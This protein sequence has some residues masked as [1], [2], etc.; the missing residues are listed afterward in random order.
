MKRASTKTAETETLRWLGEDA[1]EYL[2][3]KE[4]GPTEGIQELVL[5][6]TGP[7]GNTTLSP[8]LE[9]LKNKAVETDDAVDW[10]RFYR[11]ANFPYA[12]ME[13][14][15]TKKKL[16]ALHNDPG[17]VTRKKEL[18]AL[19]QTRKAQFYHDKEKKRTEKEAFEKA[20]QERKK[21][22]QHAKDQAAIRKLDVKSFHQEDK[23]RIKTE[24]GR[25][26]TQKGTDTSK[27][28]ATKLKK[29]TVLIAKDVFFVLLKTY[30][31]SPLIF[32]KTAIDLMQRFFNRVL[33]T[34]F[35]KSFF[36]Y[37]KD[38]RHK[39]VKELPRT[40]KN[41]N[42]H[43]KTGIENLKKEYDDTLFH[44]KLS[45]L[46]LDDF[47]G[48]KQCY[49]EIKTGREF[50]NS[51][52]FYNHDVPAT[53]NPF[54][55]VKEIV[56]EVCILTDMK[57][58]IRTNHWTFNVNSIGQRIKKF[59]DGPK[60]KDKAAFAKTLVDDYTQGKKREDLEKE[61]LLYVLVNLKQPNQETTQTLYG[62]ADDIKKKALPY[63]LHGMAASAVTYTLSEKDHVLN[64]CVIANLW[65]NHQDEGR[66]QEWKLANQIGINYLLHLSL[67]Q[68]LDKK[69]GKK[70][71]KDGTALKLTA[72]RKA[73]EFSTESTEVYGLVKKEFEQRL[74]LV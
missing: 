56:S 11:E 15:Q 42:I 34:F 31:R 12:T 50:L 63:L 70:T 72:K 55:S 1:E 8:H 22:K 66:F 32:R 68:T 18:L 69:E 53:E 73:T 9:E 36:K 58:M 47:T 3:L 51:T 49:E 44:K 28:R 26:K 16:C 59:V 20:K 33:S 35:G 13:T 52:H 65:V 30:L 4:E 74:G 23:E 61:V 48:L 39:L 2:R 57:P 27:R 40:L 37:T 45:S 14:F 67:S 64:R 43:F 29:K 71:K 24:K 41:Q 38:E 21:E 54:V 7:G 17:K 5:K 60:G 10:L 46:Y 25:A 62:L 6:R 19:A